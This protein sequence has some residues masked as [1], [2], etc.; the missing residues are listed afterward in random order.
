MSLATDQIADRRR[1][2]RKVTFWRVCAFLV[3][4]VGIIALAFVA[5]GKARAPYIARISIT[6][7]ITAQQETRDLIKEVGEDKSVA[8]VI[9]SINSPGGTTT[10]SEELFHSLRALAQKKPMVAFVD[11]TAASGSYIAAMSADHIVA[12]ET[13]IV[14]SIGVLIQYPEM[15]KLLNTV[16]INMEAVKSSPLKAEPSGV[17]PTSPEARAALQRLIDDSYVWFK[18]LVASRRSLS[19]ADLATVTDGRVFT[20]RQGLQLKLIDELGGER[21][22][23]VWLEQ[24]KNVAKDLPVRNREPEGK[25][26]RPSILSLAATGADLAGAQDVSTILR[27][28]GTEVDMTRLDGLLAVW[29]PA[30]GR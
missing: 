20:G 2:R 4:A 12:R 26:K 24:K 15:S 11:G 13:S 10:G 18:D 28:A 9:L 19:G 1:L 23:I 7:L 17:R 21:Q 6:G 14:G 3:L 27:Q 8:G 16:G 29:H 25:L 5:A 22:A 30:L